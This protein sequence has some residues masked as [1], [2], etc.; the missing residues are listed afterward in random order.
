MRYNYHTH[1]WRC[2]HAEENERAYI[3]NAIAA[4]MK[5]LGFSDHAPYL[6]PDGY[7]SSFRMFPEQTKEYA[8]TIAALREEYRGQIDI[9][10]G[11]EME[12]Y[13]AYLRE[14]LAM[15]TQYPVDYL[16]LGQHFI[17]NEAT[18]KYSGNPTSDE[19]RLATYVDEVIA[20]MGTGLFTYVAHPDLL[21]FT[22]ESG[23]YRREMERLCEASAASTV[24]LEINLLG[25][26]G[27]RNYPCEAFFELCGKVGAPVVIGSDAHTA[28]TVFHEESY[29]EALRICEKFRLNL[30]ENPVLR[31]IRLD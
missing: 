28:D 23:V 10:I 15:V 29:S 14:T 30:I 11:Y 22:G 19:C 20:A 1:T 26:R 12:Y 2:R 9:K 31:P 13:P 18:G 6:F 21:N 5:V 17:E 8:E 7:Y 25:I 24:P 3:E 16:I 4:G 27:G